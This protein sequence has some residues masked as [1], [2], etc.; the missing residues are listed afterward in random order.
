MGFKTIIVLIGFAAA[1]VSCSKQPVVCSPKTAVDIH[2]VEIRNLG[3]GDN[4]VQMDITKDVPDLPEYM[5]A[6]RLSPQQ[7]QI[8][9]PSAY[10]T[11]LR[12]DCRIVS[13]VFHA[14]TS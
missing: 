5:F 4:W 13:K 11:F 2:R 6:I 1:L 8:D 12:E 3:V 9:G 10:V 7:V 14:I